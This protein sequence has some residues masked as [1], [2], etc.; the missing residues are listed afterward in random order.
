MIECFNCGT[1]EIGD[2]LQ[3]K[4]GK[5]RGWKFIHPR[6]YKGDI[7]FCPK[8]KKEIEELALKIHDIVDFDYIYLKDLMNEKEM[9]NRRQKML[10]NKLEVLMKKKENSDLN[11]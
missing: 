1:K 6:G 4:F 2:I 7:T 11:E 5:L 9:L 8:C 10:D 3:T